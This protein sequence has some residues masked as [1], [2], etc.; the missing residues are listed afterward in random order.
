[1]SDINGRNFLSASPCCSGPECPFGLSS[2]EMTLTK[3]T[4]DFFPQAV[5]PSVVVKNFYYVCPVATGLELIRKCLWCI[6]HT[7]IIDIKSPNKK[8]KAKQQK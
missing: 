4:P 3:C 7:E 6:I 5:W 8:Y 2:T 1:M